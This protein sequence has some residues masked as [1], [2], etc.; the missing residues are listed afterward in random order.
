MTWSAFYLAC[1]LIGVVLSLLAFVGGS[2]H[3]PHF[4]LHLPHGAHAGVPTLRRE[5]QGAG[6]FR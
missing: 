4:H 1:F 5:A 3:L 6:N 2:V